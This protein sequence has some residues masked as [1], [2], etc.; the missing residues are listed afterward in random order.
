LLSPLSIPQH[1]MRPLPFNTTDT[2]A[3]H[4]DGKVSD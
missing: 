2:R 4:P 1:L 3:H